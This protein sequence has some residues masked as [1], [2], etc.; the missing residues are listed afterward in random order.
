MVSLANVGFVVSNAYKLN[1]MGIGFEELIGEVN[2]G[3][4]GFNALLN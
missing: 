4:N 1:Q 2:S 3:V